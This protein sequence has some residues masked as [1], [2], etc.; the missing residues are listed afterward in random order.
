MKKTIAFVLCTMVVLTMCG[1][2]KNNEVSI[3]D[4]ASAPEEEII[5]MP[6]PFVEGSLEESIQHAGFDFSVPEQIAGYA[7][8]TILSI[9][10]E[11]IQAYYYNDDE[12]EGLDD[13]A[14]NKI[15]WE[16]VDWNSDSLMIRKAKGNDDVSGDYNTYSEVHSLNIGDLQITVK[17]ENHMIY[18]ATWTD[19]SYSFAI[20]TNNALSEEQIADIIKQVK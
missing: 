6:N 8:R 9:E 18:V 10:D 7:H 17:G 14:L 12:L 16:N 1:C 13:D 20:T 11:L 4:D 2:G 19:G 15:D 5:G 3:I